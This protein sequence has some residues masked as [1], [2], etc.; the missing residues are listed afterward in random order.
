MTLHFLVVGKELLK[1]Y[2]TSLFVAFFSLKTIRN[3]FLSL[4]R[5]CQNCL[6]IRYHYLPRSAWLKVNPGS[7]SLLVRG[8][9]QTYK[10]DHFVARA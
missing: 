6:L 10:L 2:Y 7:E 9:K 1:F 5:L 8:I 4:Q 3:L